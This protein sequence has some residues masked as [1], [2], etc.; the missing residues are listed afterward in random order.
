[1]ISEYS[2]VLKKVMLFD[3]IST[4]EISAILKCSGS[5][6][7][8]FRKDEIILLAGNKPTG[9]GIVL[10]GRLHIERGDSDGSHV[11]LSEIPPGDIFA[12]TLCCADISESPVTVLAVT[13]SVVLTLKF[14]QLL[15]ACDSPCVF[16][17]RLIEN[18]LRLVAQKNL[19]LQQRLGI[20][21]L[22][23][24]RAKVLAYLETL[25]GNGG[26]IVLPFNRE[27]LADFLCVERTAL[28]HELA[29]MKRDGLIEYKKNVF[30]VH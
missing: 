8:I 19:R 21:S 7:K 13:E 11:L 16:H 20:L 3:G 24:I 1:M 28:S 23:S 4:D 10:S 18:M 6:P 26:E 29:R 30:A 25:P 15:H 22:K 12:E 27:Q 17:T 2:A 14:P 9:I 5:A